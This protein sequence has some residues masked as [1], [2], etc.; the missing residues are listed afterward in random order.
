MMGSFRSYGFVKDI[1][2]QLLLKGNFQTIIR[3]TFWAIIA[4]SG[5]F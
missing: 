1:F 4:Q 3:V 2:G 5:F